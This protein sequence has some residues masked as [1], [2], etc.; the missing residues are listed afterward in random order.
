MSFDAQVSFLCLVAPALIGAIY[1][2]EPIDRFFKRLRP[3]KKT[4]IMSEWKEYKK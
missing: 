1:L 4:C 3:R 2:I